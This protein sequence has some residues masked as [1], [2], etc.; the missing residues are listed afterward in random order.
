MPCDPASDI[1]RDGGRR[2]ARHGVLEIQI[3]RA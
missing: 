3:V 2:E 1:A